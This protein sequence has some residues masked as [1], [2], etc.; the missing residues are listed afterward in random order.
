M[1]IYNIYVYI[2][3]IC[4]YIIYACICIKNNMQII[5]WNIVL[6]MYANQMLYVIKMI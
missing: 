2:L 6:V 5:L 4:I 3:Y 1:Y